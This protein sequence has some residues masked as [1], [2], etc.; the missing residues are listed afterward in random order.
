MGNIRKHSA[1][2]AELERAGAVKIAGAFYD[3]RTGAVDFF[4]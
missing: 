2:I 4:A 3:V 1:V